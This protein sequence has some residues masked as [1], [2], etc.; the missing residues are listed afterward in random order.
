MTP[1]EAGPTRLKLVGLLGALCT[2]G[3]MS[4]DMY[5]PA[6]P[7]MATELDAAAPQIQLPMVPTVTRAVIAA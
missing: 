4:I 6:F 1:T 7:S 2:L 5:L 3:P